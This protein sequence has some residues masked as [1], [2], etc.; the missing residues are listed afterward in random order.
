MSLREN[1]FA[2]EKVNKQ[3]ASLIITIA[4][5]LCHCGFGHKLEEAKVMNTRAREA[6]AVDEDGAFAKASHNC[7]K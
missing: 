3:F 7:T 2:R 5:L 6:E 4:F 1:H